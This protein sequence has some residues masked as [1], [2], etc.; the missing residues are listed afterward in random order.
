MQ[1]NGP[2]L[3]AIRE[4]SGY[5]QSDLA[6]AAEVSQPRISRLES[7]TGNARPATVRKLAAV[8]RVPVAALIREEAA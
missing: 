6:R 3:Q 7:G 2:A 4:R 5:S 1:I 8:L